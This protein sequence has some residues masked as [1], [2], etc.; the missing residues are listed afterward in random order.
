MRHTMNKRP[1]S[2]HVA[3][4]IALLLGGCAAVGPDFKAPLPEA[5]A[6]F[7]DWHGGSAELAADTARGGAPVDWAMFGDP[8][9]DALQARALAANPD[10]RTAALHFAQSRRQRAVVASQQVPEVELQAGVM[11]NRVS[12]FGDATRVIDALDIPDK[13]H[14]IDVLATP[15]TLY[16][17]G[18]DAYWEIDLWG[19]VRRS[20]EAADADVVASQALLAQVQ[21][22]VQAEVARQYFELRSAQRQ[23][24]LARQDLAAA[25]ETLALVKARADSG[26]T[27]DLDVTRQDALVADLRSRLPL[28]LAQEAQALNQIT[29][30]LGQRPGSLND[31]LAAR[32]DE[33]AQR[34]LPDLSLGVPSEVA[35]RRPD[36]RSAEARLHA[37]TANV[38]VAVAD[39]YPRISIGA[40]FGF[41]S[42]SASNF[43]SWGSRQWNIGPAL[44][45]PIF[46]QGRRRATVTIRDLQ[47]QEAAVAYQQT[48]LRA[49]HEI[50][51]A[52][53]AYNAERRRNVDLAAK[54]RESRRALQLARTRY[55]A[56]LTDFLVQLDAERTLLQARRD[57]VDSSSQL[58]L[59]LVAVSKALAATPVAAPTAG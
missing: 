5:P 23:L 35:L 1:D 39:L 36:I 6:R 24:A 16:D 11:R 27:T 50:D 49:W 52:V 54:E 48:V 3:L 46:D 47:Q 40:G 14:V 17:V 45:L 20:I 56:G 21:L 37:A 58:A 44:E 19:R 15:Y 41:A 13:D 12:E 53:S 34:A 10:L 7:G 42:V 51:D 2:L 9:L 31:E 43:G 55:D 38:G 18:F 33:E 26:L 29:L 59:R 57:H 32:G 25:A 8:V 22:S 30:L 28:L 4:A